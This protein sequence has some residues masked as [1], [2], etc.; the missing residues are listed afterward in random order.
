MLWCRPPLP[1]RKGMNARLQLT[2]VD[3]ANHRAG[4]VGD[5]RSHFVSGLLQFN[6]KRGRRRG[7]GTVCGA[8]AGKNSGARDHYPVTNQAGRLQRLAAVNLAGDG[9]RGRVKFL[10]AAHGTDLR[11]LRRQ[12]VVL[13][14]V[15]GIWFFS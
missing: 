7:R 8:G 3:G 15:R 14:W 6:A 2:N 13:H 10:N 5:R 4:R 9:T 12:F 11:K 1:S